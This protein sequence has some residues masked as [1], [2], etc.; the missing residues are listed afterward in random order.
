[1][2]SNLAFPHSK[3]LWFAVFT[4]NDGTAT[5]E[6]EIYT[7]YEHASN[8]VEMMNANP[9][10]TRTYFLSDGA[11][12]KESLA[13]LLKTMPEPQGTPDAPVTIEQIE[14]DNL[15][16]QYRMV[17]MECHV[18]YLSENKQ[19]I[20]FCSIPTAV[21]FF[22][23]LYGERTKLFTYPEDT[24]NNVICALTGQSVLSYIHDPYAETLQIVMLQQYDAFVNEVSK[25]L[26]LYGCTPAFERIQ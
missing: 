17:S 24:H 19:D 1:M 26:E 6:K 9:S 2:P 4:V 15:F 21:P 22:V 16:S 18:A 11:S 14:P 13:N 25:H 20:V 23:Y 7:T 12:T 8:T 5:A 10:K 3:K